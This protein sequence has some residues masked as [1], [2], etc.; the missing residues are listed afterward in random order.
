MYFIY[1]LTG[2]VALVNSKKFLTAKAADRLAS[3]LKNVFYLHV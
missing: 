1:I 3:K 2:L